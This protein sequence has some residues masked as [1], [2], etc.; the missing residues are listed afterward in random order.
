MVNLH[1]TEWLAIQPEGVGENIFKRQRQFSSLE[2]SKNSKTKQKTTNKKHGIYKNP[3]GI[4]VWKAVNTDIGVKVP[5]DFGLPSL[6]CIV[7]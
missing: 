4:A 3:E 1:Y 6:T 5:L 2:W 7:C